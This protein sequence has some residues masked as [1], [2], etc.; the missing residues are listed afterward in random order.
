[1]YTESL[2]EMLSH[3]WITDMTNKQSCTGGKAP[4][5]IKTKRKPQTKQTS[6]EKRVYFQ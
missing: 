4:P 3:V 6:N 5:N 2:D 1:M